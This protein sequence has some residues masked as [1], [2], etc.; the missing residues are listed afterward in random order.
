MHYFGNQAIDKMFETVKIGPNSEILDAGSGFGSSARYILEKI[1]KYSYVTACEYQKEYHDF[2]IELT[3][4]QDYKNQLKFLND[5]LVNVNFG[6]GVQFDLVYSFL[7]ILHIV[8]DL[9]VKLFKN[10]A[11]FMKKGAVFYIEDY[12]RDGNLS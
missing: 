9:R 1:K 11:K 2:A 6:E 3:K 12:F 8:I 10:L 5:D 7:V 4:C